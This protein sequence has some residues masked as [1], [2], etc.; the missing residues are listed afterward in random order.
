MSTVLLVISY[1][2]LEFKGL[3]ADD[4]VDLS[5]RIW[6]VRQ[7]HAKVVDYL[8]INPSSA[9]GR[10]YIKNPRNTYDWTV[11]FQP[12]RKEAWIGLL[13]FSLLTPFLIAVIT[14]YSKQR[15]QCQKNF[16]FIDYV[17]SITIISKI[18]SDS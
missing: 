10:F 1:H 14:Y 15:H 7:N 13:L 6:G 17:N 12:L 8:I 3:V 16:I 5:I 11:F 2:N 18:F 4:L 9:I